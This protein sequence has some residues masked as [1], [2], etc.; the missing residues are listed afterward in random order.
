MTDKGYFGKADSIHMYKHTKFFVKRQAESGIFYPI[1][2][3]WSSNPAPQAAFPPEMHPA[4]DLRQP[5]V[6][7]SDRAAPHLTRFLFLPTKW[8][9]L[10]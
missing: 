2:I 5:G 7:P 1:C 3:I 4:G 9:S 10:L 8:P 6:R